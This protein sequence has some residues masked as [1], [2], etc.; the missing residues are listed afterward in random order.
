[1]KKGFQGRGV[2]KD[3]RYGDSLGLRS[4]PVGETIVMW[5]WDQKDICATTTYYKKRG[6]GIWKTK[7]GHKNG[8]VVTE[9]R[10]VE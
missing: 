2:P 9:V 10:R 1:M 8:R 7:R 4:L 5:G 3:R 6:Y